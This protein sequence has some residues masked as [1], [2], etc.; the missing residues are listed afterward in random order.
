MMFCKPNS[1]TLLYRSLGSFRHCAALKL[2][3][4]MQR[5][6]RAGRVALPVTCHW[7]T[8]A[9]R[10]AHPKAYPPPLHDVFDNP[11]GCRFGR[12]CTNMLPR[13]YWRTAQSVAVRL[14]FATTCRGAWSI[15]ET[16][17]RDLC[18]AMEKQ[19]LRVHAR[20]SQFRWRCFHKIHRKT[21]S[22]TM[23]VS[24]DAANPATRTVAVPRAATAVVLG[25]TG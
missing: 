9:R 8:A 6:R 10:T 19:N 18:L 2:E 14:Q 23:S 25:K 22:V 11:E 21:I 16:P 24:R 4:N 13:G 17:R 7:M 1:H 20:S 12:W 5:R 3:V 15:L